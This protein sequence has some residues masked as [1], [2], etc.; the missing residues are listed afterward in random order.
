MLFADDELVCD[1]TLYT[2]RAPSPYPLH[3]LAHSPF[4]QRTY[5]CE[6]VGGTY[7]LFRHRKAT[8]RKKITYFLKHR[9]LR[10]LLLSRHVI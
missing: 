6:E 1:W 8:R 7:L 4:S 10:I 3:A 5:R 2:A 9:G